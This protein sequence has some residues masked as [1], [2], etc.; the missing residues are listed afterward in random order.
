M[1]DMIAEPTGAVLNGTDAASPAGKPA[2]EVMLDSRGGE[3][4]QRI[5]KSTER[6]S[7]MVRVLARLRASEA[8]DGQEA[9]AE[10]AEE[11]QPET[12]EEPPA[13]PDAAETVEDGESGPTTEAEPDPEEKLAEVAAD[14]PDV[15]ALRAEAESA[16]AEAA[17]LR[18]LMQQAGGQRVDEDDR[19]GY[20]ADPLAHVRQHIGRLLG[21]AADHKLVDEELGAI[22]R[23]LTY[24]AVGDSKIDNDLAA[25]R[26]REQSDR[27]WRI[28][29]Q[30]QA[31]DRE[32]ALQRAQRDSGV[33]FVES[34]YEA[35]K[36]KYVDATIGAKKV[37]RTP[38]DVAFDLLP[39]F[40]QRGLLKVDGLTDA[41]IAQEA[42]RLTNLSFKRDADE[43]RAL[44][45]APAQT[46]AP[47][48]ASATG[49]KPGAPKPDQ[50]KA[51][52]KPGTA[53][54]R[55]LSAKQAAAAPIAKAAGQGPKKTIVEIDPNDSDARYARAREIAERRFKKPQ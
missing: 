53:P 43:F 33:K 49:S 13:E 21:V 31:A 8:A 26:A 40:V 3:T 27:R 41:Q 19:R 45:T 39:V 37:G 12:A 42:L 10:D 18:Q 2:T 44:L 36:A 24:A 5:Q 16:K 52:A 54:P 7:P 48:K 51:P 35:D 38:A 17:A 4:P 46:S 50:S 55:T 29:Q 32:L 30:A 1:P 22:Q 15:V 6:E 34:L 11:A 20:I 14:A 25:Q 47:A 23:E 28:D 9:P